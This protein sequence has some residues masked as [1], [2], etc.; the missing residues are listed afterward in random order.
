MPNAVERI[1]RSPSMN[2]VTGGIFIPAEGTP[3]EV[4]ETFDKIWAE[5]IP[6]AAPLRDYALEKGALFTPASGDGA[7]DKVWPEI[8]ADAW[9]FHAAGRT[10]MSPDEL[11]IPKP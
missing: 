3:P 8:Q 5:V 1:G 7:K 6:N 2:S 10:A 4:F 9:S 11:G